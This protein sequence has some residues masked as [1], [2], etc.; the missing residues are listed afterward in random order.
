LRKAFHT[1]VG[2]KVISL[3]S[4]AGDTEQV[5]VLKAKL[6]APA[7]LIYDCVSKRVEHRFIKFPIAVSKPINFDL[8]DQVPEVDM[9]HRKTVKWFYNF[10]KVK[11]G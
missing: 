8:Y 1:Q 5:H 7:Y 9:T 11:R 10:V 6:K 4:L 2:T 3:I